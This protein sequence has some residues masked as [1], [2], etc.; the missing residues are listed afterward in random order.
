M[1]IIPQNFIKSKIISTIV[2]PHGI[3]DLI[4]SIQSNTTKPL[5]YINS[6]CATSSVVSSL[7]PN[8][9]LGYN[10][11]FLF[12]SVIHF[13]HDY[14]KTNNQILEVILSLATIISFTQCHDLFYLYMTL[15]H[16][17]KHYSSNWK[18]IR[19]NKEVNICLII[20]FTTGCFYTIIDVFSQPLLFYRLYRGIILAHVIYQELYIHNDKN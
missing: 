2:A 17:P 9:E 12:G 4:H 7:H 19:K 15:L 14:P 20:L 10:I 5:L 16:V 8:L 13:S 18:Y 1:I 6:A 3:T 11:F